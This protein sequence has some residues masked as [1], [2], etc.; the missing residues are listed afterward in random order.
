[1]AALLFPAL[2]LLLLVASSVALPPRQQLYL[3]IQDNLPAW[4][5]DVKPAS[6]HHNVHADEALPV[7][8]GASTAATD[9]DQTAD[10]PSA[11]TSLLPFLKDDW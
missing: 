9:F 6:I 4:A 11:P 2:V 5:N 8:D 3:T 1:M 10:L 7:A